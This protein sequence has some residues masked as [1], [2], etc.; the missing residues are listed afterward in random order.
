MQRK[1]RRLGLLIIIAINFKHIPYDEE[2]IV[3]S[4]WYEFYCV[5]LPMKKKSKWSTIG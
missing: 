1:D 5:I 2:R 3:I 4:V